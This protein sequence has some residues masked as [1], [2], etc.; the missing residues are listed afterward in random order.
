MVPHGRGAR[1]KKP[2]R[3]RKRYRRANEQGSKG[4]KAVGDGTSVSDTD[5]SGKLTAAS[6]ERRK[7]AGEAVRRTNGKGSQPRGEEEERR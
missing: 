3:P 1:E 7:T 2:A 5:G 4:K 6:R